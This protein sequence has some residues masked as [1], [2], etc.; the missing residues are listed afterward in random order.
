MET[1][2]LLITDFD[3]QTSTSPP[4]KTNIRRRQSDDA[5]VIHKISTSPIKKSL[6]PTYEHPLQDLS[7]NVLHTDEFSDDSEYDP[8][9]IKSSIQLIKE[10]E[11][12]NN[13]LNNSKDIMMLNNST[14]ASN[15]SKTSNSN[16]NTRNL[17]EHIDD[18]QNESSITTISNKN[19]SEIE[20]EEGTG[21][22]TQELAPGQVVRRKKAQSTTTSTTTTSTVKNNQ[23]ASFPLINKPNHKP[24]IENPGFENNSFDK[25]D[26][27]Y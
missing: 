4:N 5:F 18:N 10:D 8:P 9:P 23:R 25:L 11:N 20:Q 22:V 13:K 3:K 7:E 19:V 6:T 24:T 12:R 27:E 21:I 17:M 1:H 14:T 16:N 15:S 2:I 26:G